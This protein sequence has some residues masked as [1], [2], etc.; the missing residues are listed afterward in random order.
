MA[1]EGSARLLGRSE[2]GTLEVGKAADIAIFDLDK[3]AYAGAADPIAALIF[4]GIDHCAHTVIVNGEI[5][6]EDSHLLRMD[7]ERLK[8]RAVT[9]SRRLLKN[10]AI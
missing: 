10:A 3:L 5:V 1:T 7:E 8:R 2:I 6:V 4:C 9:A